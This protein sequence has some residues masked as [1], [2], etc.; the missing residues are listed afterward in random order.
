MK[1]LILSY[2]LEDIELICDRVVFFRDG[3][4]V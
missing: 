2:K 4:F 3:K 1:I